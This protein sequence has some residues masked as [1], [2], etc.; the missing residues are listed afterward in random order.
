MIKL[1]T[2]PT[3]G[4]CKIIELKMHEKN[5]NFT[6]INDEEILIKKG[7]EQVPVLELEDGT[8]I[9][10]LIDIRNWINKQNG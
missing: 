8:M 9:N 1:Y 10:H 6:L 3:C 2:L 5:I 7:I 4:T